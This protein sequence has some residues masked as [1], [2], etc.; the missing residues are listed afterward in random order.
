MERGI[1]PMKKM[2]GAPMG[3]LSEEMYSAI[4]IPKKSI[5]TNRKTANP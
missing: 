2:Q 1:I 4:K 3:Q 5:L